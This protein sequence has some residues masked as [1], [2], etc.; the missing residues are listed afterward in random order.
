MFRGQ[1][2]STSPMNDKTVRLERD[3]LHYQSGGRELEYRQSGMIG[4]PYRV[5][6]ID[7]DAARFPQILN[8]RA[9]FVRSVFSLRKTFGCFRDYAEAV[10]REGVIK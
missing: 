5:L 8:P 10:G 7:S 2:T 9:R 1:R 3:A 6:R 4:H